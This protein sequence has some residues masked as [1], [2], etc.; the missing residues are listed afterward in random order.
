MD[1]SL[2]LVDRYGL[3]LVIL[4]LLVVG[5]WRVWKFVRPF[6]QEAL[7]EH[8]KLIKDLRAG[9]RANVASLR[10]QSSAMSAHAEA[11]ALNAAFLRKIY[12]SMFPKAQA[13]AHR[14][15]RLLVVEDSPTDYLLL[16][17]RLEPLLDETRAELLHADSLSEAIRQIELADAVILDLLL[18]DASDP[19]TNKLFAEL[20]G[21]PIVLYTSS[22][23]PTADRLAQG[24]AGLGSSR[25]RVRS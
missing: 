25:S 14:P 6:A 2:D 23:D 3:P 5:V 13:P 21:L 20:S 8:V 15:A 10:K 11:L 16:R 4:C 7:E 17:K 24:L 18:P 19:K 9:T 22:P 1:A 12:D